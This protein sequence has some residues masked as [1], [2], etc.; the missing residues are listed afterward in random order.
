M[1]RM[2]PAHARI[3]WMAAIVVLLLLP[4][5]APADAQSA[6][7]VKPVEPV[8]GPPSPIEGWFSISP[9]PIRSAPLWAFADTEV[10]IWMHV[11]AYDRDL[12]DT[13]TIT[14]HGVTLNRTSVGIVAHRG[15]VQSFPLTMTADPA[16][17]SA[18]LH[19]KFTN[20][21]VDGN[22]HAWSRNVDVQRP[23]SVAFESPVPLAGA[24]RYGRPTMHHVGVTDPLPF[25]VNVTNHGST[26]SKA[27]SVGVRFQDQPFATAAVPALAS[28]ESRIVHVGDFLLSDQPGDFGWGYGMSTAF[29]LMI[30]EG[31]LQLA[32]WK[33]DFEDGRIIDPVAEMVGVEFHTGVLAQPEDIHLVLGQPSWITVSVVNYGSETVRNIRI[34]VSEAPIPRTYYGPGSFLKET[35]WVTVQPGETVRVNISHTPI[36]A[37]EH[38]VT[39]QSYLEQWTSPIETT[40]ILD[41]PVSGKPTTERSLTLGLGDSA[42]LGF[43]LTSTK[44]MGEVTVG[45]AVAPLSFFREDV[46]FA[47]FITGSDVMSFETSPSRARLAPGTP[48]E[49]TLDLVTRAAGSYAVVPYVIA[50]GIVYPLVAEPMESA[51]QLDPSHGPLGPSMPMTGEMPSAAFEVIVQSGPASGA[52]VPLPLLAFVGAFGG[53]WTYRWRKVK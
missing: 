50:D 30:P 38:M 28:G 46:P 48:I 7:P 45:A 26:P 39:V 15:L 51:W 9:D 18:S 36:V 42:R 14:A 41:G 29:S 16:A 17:P 21:L 20:A 27:F 10:K 40:V 53:Y 5:L 6:R 4:A 34:D 43:R 12:D 47:R 35:R 23:V 22:V 31:T 33:F 13:I 11:V 8:S 24:D 19:A 25:K 2:V 32:A 1:I 3:P 37:G 49:A 44:D 52:L